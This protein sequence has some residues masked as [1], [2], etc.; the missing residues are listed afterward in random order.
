MPD[1]FRALIAEGDSKQ[2]SVD[3]KD[4]PHGSLPAGEIGE[5]KKVGA[6]PRSEF[7]KNAFG[8]VIGGGTI[9]L[10]ARPRDVVRLPVQGR[11]ARH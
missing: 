9:G 3:F 6:S 4:I 8:G 11:L 7:G 10:H 1:T 2:Y 5:H